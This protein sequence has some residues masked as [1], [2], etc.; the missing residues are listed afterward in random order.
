MKADIKDLE[1]LKEECLQNTDN[2]E[3]RFKRNNLVFWNVLDGEESWRR[4]IR[5][6]EDI[7]IN[8]MKL[9]DTEDIVIE[10]A[11]RSGVKQSAK[12]GKESSGPIHYRF[13]HWGDKEYVIY[14]V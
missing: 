7:I 3:N 10:R 5:L 14:N 9:K 2:L 12:D 13:L 11:H 6:L 1:R 8:H 4:Y